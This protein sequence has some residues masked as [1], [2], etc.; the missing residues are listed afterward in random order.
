MGKEDFV[1][2]AANLLADFVHPDWCRAKML[3]AFIA[4]LSNA[5]VSYG[6]MF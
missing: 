5:I 2:Y 4:A 3:N 1:Q 6:Y